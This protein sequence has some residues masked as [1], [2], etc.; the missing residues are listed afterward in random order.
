MS[1]EQTNGATELSPE[2]QA[3]LEAQVSAATG[4]AAEVVALSIPELTGRL[5]GLDLLTL[6]CVLAAEKAKG[7]AAR[8]GAIAAISAAIDAHPDQVAM[9]AAAASSAYEPP[10]ADDADDDPPVIAADVAADHVLMAADDRV[11]DAYPVHEDTG[12]YLVPLADIATMQSHGFA[13]VSG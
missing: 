1:D 11:T 10:A 9:L 5:A 12:H 7:D 3:A 6:R 8:T 2:E 4:V 13:V